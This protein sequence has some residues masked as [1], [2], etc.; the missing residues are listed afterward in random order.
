MQSR[1]ASLGR[2]W[3]ALTDDHERGLNRAN[4]SFDKF[5]SGSTVDPLALVGAYRSG[6]TQLIY[7][8][9]ENSWARGIPA[10][11]IGDPGAMLDSYINSKYNII[12]DWI[13]AEIDT[14]LGAYAENRP[15][16]VDWFPN[17]D[18][19]TKQ[20]Y[21][22]EYSES[23]QETDIQRTALFFDEVE[24]SYRAFI[25]A[26]DKDDDNPL[27]Q[28]N[29]GLQDCMKLWSFGMISAFEFIGEADWG[30]MKEIR[31]P[32]LEVPEV[33]QLLRD[34]RPDAVEFANIIWWLA[35]G[36]TGIIVKLIEELPDD[37]SSTAPEWLRNLAKADFRDTR[38]INNLWTELDR[39]D[40]EPALRALL[41]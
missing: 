32:P 26:M 13:K 8:L 37:I 33:R 22:A 18:S 1:K 28:I 25:R 4:E 9:F 11:Y 39:Q 19:E 30:R 21:I 12:N 2:E 15:N 34:R 36:R 40:W 31:I 17:I 10:F 5:Q 3:Q 14:Q 6:K 16:D 27:R 7:H 20:N 41:F 35:R 23:I 29:D 38:L 24:Q